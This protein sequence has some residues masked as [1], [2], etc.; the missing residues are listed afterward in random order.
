MSNFFGGAVSTSSSRYFPGSS[1]PDLATPC[2][3]RRFPRFNLINEAA[4][5][6]PR[7]DDLDGIGSTVVPLSNHERSRSS[8]S[9]WTGRTYH[10]PCALSISK[11]LCERGGQAPEIT[12]EDHEQDHFLP[13]TPIA[14]TP[15]LLQYAHL[16]RAE[17]FKLGTFSV[18]NIIL[19]KTIGVGIFSVPSSILAGVGSVGMALLIWVVGALISFCGLAVYLDLGTALP[20]SGGEKVYLERIFRKPR[21]LATCVFMSYVVLLGFSTPNCVVLGEY[22]VYALGV[23]PSQ[24]K[25][26]S[27][28]VL[29]VT[30]TCLIHARWPGFGLQTINFLGIGKMVII[31]IIV[32]SGLGSVVSGTP[33]V[34]TNTSSSIAADKMLS[35]DSVDSRSVVTR[36][37]SSLFASSSTQPYD[38]ATALLQVLY[39][40]RGYNTANSVL[41]EVRNPVTT[42][43]KAAPIALSIAS[44]AYILVNIAYL[45]VVDVSVL[46][47]SGVVVAGYFFTAVFG[48]VIGGRLLPWPIVLSAYGSIA[49]TSYAQSRLNQELAKE[50]LFPCSGFWA[51]S[52]PWGTPAAALFLHWLVSVVVIVAPPAGEMYNFLVEIGGY[53]VSV[54]GVAVAGGLLYLQ[55]SPREGWQSPRPARKVYVLLFLVSNVVLLV[56]PWIPP[57]RDLTV[58][59][60]GGD[61]EGERRKSEWDV[62]EGRFP[63]YAYPATGLLILGLGVVYWVWQTRVGPWWLD[64]EDRIICR[65]LTEEDVDLCEWKSELARSRMD[66]VPPVI[67]PWDRSG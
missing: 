3:P 47:E 57:R 25:V 48:D 20:R 10:R 61:G 9:D 30:S 7:Y 53:P 40:F 46:R 22:A 23:E 50:A 36:D 17:E 63:Y 59:G 18:I 64:L 55:C 56:L 33:G 66:G 12:T 24:W 19:G 11:E 34:V 58:G 60:A 67:P 45:C 65:A 37:F 35:A 49:A 14:I 44:A 6:A 21:M 62:A 52:K 1:Y 32:L 51:S 41:S 5:L 13:K 4:D 43:Q 16:Q 38:Y 31:A 8:P 15:S 42:L 2:T 29:A 28:A 54:I 26:R 27:I 39:C